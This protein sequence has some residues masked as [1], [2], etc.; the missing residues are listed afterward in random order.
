MLEILFV[1]G[2]QGHLE[3]DVLTIDVG[4]ELFLLEDGRVHDVLEIGLVQSAVPVID[5]VSSVHD[6][7]EDVDQI[8]ER[9]L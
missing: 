1:V 2:G 6:L 4:E 3:A 5:N 8:F 9:N 7:P